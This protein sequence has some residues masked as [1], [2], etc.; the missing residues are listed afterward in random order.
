M[1]MICPVCSHNLRIT[2]ITSKVFLQDN[3][4]CDS[5]DSF[6]IIQEKDMS[7]YYSETYHQE[8]NFKQH[9]QDSWL[10]NYFS[11]P[12]NYSRYQFLMRNSKQSDFKNI[13]EIGGGNGDFYS[14]MNVK[15]HP[16]QYTIVEPNPT[17][18]L[19]A[20]NLQYHNLLFEDVSDNQ[21]QGI[22]LIV[23]FHVLEHIFDVDA[24]FARV[25]KLGVK[26]LLMEVPNIIDDRVKEDSLLRHPHYHH[27]SGKSLK[28]LIEKQGFQNYTIDSIRP[29]TYHPYDKVPISSRV[30]NKII[31]RNEA[32]DT[33]GL[34]LRALIDLT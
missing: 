17:Y 9:T 29:I 6:H 12:R 7:A 18:N 21:L 26:Y 33:K 32:A 23:M 10:K 14:L 22:D 28:M 31:G 24:F 19:I 1:S 8:F 27:Y 2:N 20:D 16:D 3:Y 13:L 11:K 34:Y 5:C 4:Y 30:F 15:N 25:K